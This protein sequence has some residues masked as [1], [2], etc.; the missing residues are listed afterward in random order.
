MTAQVLLV[1]GESADLGGTIAPDLARNL[2]FKPVRPVALRSDRPVVAINPMPVY[3]NT[4]PWLFLTLHG[5]FSSKSKGPIEVRTAP[6][7]PN[8]KAG[9]LLL[10]TIIGNPTFRTRFWVPPG[11]T[12]KPTRIYFLNQD[13]TPGI[14]NA[15]LTWF[16][17]RLK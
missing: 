6:G 15:S 13:K 4:G 17:E 10:A 3:I 1:E 14:G 16:V 9:G 11:T 8:V 5:R 7:A 2:A 12:T